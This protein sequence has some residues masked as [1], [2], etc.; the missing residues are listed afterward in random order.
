METYG[1]QMNKAESE[2]VSIVLI[3]SG[4]EPVEDPAEAHIIL[5]N[6]CS[7]RKTAEE[8]VWGRLGAL[9]GYKKR[10]VRIVLMGCMA[11]RLKDKI[12]AKEPSV[13]LVVCNFDKKEL[14]LL[15]ERI[16][17]QK[18]H[19]ISNSHDHYDFLSIHE[20]SG[21]KAFIPIMHGCN[22]FCTYCIVPHVRGREI[23]RA[24]VS[25]LNEIALLE[26]RGIKEITLLGQNVNSYC[27]DVN[28]VNLDF[29]GLLKLIISNIG[30]IHWVRFLTSHPKDF[31]KELIDIIATSQHLCKHIHLPVQHGSNRI[32]EQM[33]R[34]Y[35]REDYLAII[36]ALKAKVPGVS[37]TT[38]ILIG[39]PGETQDD[40][41][42]TLDLMKT[43]EFDDAFMYRY[44]RI[45]GT[46]AYDM[47]NQLEEKVKLQRLNE[48]IQIQR[49]I[50]GKKKKNKVGRVMK[51]LIEGMSKHSDK[52]LLARSEF[53][54]M[55]II[56]GDSA[57][58]GKMVTLKI[59]GLK[60]N[61][62]LGE[63]ICD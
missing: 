63:K 41:D 24:P 58:I 15:L 18:P 13:D 22:N 25:I 59:G 53:D 39:F 48:I 56:P 16:Q 37:I 1:C 11:E 9:K 54:D 20:N 31:P 2:A 49:K 19:V 47:E 60:G 23:S 21:F 17:D 27:Y 30:G 29:T 61:T 12:F 6:T 36:E 43:V 33:E 7:V 3:E 45:E 5:L 8:R 26:K 38:D 52:E 57:D 42:Q 46:K 50:A 14:P 28:G 34:K 32:L 55:V 51:A 35:S 40:F 10:D 4:W 62:L 44:N